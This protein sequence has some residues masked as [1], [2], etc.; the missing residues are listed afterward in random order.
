[1][2]GRGV[3][4]SLLSSVM[5]AAIAFVAGQLPALSGTQVWA[6]RIVLTVPGILFL[7]AVSGRWFWFSGEFK[8]P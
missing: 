1:M 3:V 6:W 7:L 2:T 4:V 8:P 5:F